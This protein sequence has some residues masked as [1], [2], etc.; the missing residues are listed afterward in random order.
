MRVR[1]TKKFGTGWGWAANDDKPIYEV[2]YSKREFGSKRAAAAFA[3]KLAFNPTP[4][5][6]KAMSQGLWID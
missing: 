5:Q 3:K 2:S 6:Y 1:V 4:E